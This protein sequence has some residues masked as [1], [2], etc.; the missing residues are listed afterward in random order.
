MAGRLKAAGA[1]VEF[2]ELKGGHWSGFEALASPET[3]GWMLSQARPAH[4]AS[5]TVRTFSPRFGSAYWA[6]IDLIDRW[7]EPA[8]LSAE[9]DG[10]GK[11]RVSARNVRAFRLSGIRAAKGVAV[12]GAQGFE[13]S[14]SPRAGGLADVR[15]RLKRAPDPGR[16]TK[17]AELPGPMKEACNTPFIVVWGSS[18]SR[19]ETAAN[20][21]KARRFATEW[22]R[23]AKGLPQAVDEQTLTDEEKKSKSLILFG[24]PAT[25]ALAREAAPSLGCRVTADEF[26]VAGRK[27]SLKG[28]HGVVLTRPSPWAPTNDRYL[29][30]CAGRFYGD[31]GD[32]PALNHKLDLI[33]DFMVFT[34]G[35]EGEGEPPALLAGYFDSDWKPDPALVEV[36]EPR[37]PP[38]AEEAPVLGPV[39]VRPR[40][41]PQPAPEAVE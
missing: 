17:N 18:G 41:S 38:V 21:A 23:F 37:A 25:S 11:V 9:D 6:R 24:T 35:S 19:Q 29:V 26:Q 7:T 28:D 5:V 22:H 8:E 32:H 10:Q 16:W 20:E 12:S 1:T 40:K 13:I 14:I 15:G 34:A 27:V 3:V 36:F 30:L 2:K 31:D 4:P 39:R 33:P